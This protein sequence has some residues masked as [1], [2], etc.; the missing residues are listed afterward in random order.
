NEILVAL[1]VGIGGMAV[2]FVMSHIGLVV[3]WRRR[4]RVW[5]NSQLHRCR[6]QNCWPPQLTAPNR[7]QDVLTFSAI[8]AVLGTVVGVIFMLVGMI[9]GLARVGLAG[10]GLALV[11][12]AIMLHHVLLVK[13]VLAKTP[14]DCWYDPPVLELADDQPGG[15][16]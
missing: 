12:G 14:D 13:R 2:S 8:P 6:D 11:C 4:E 15:Y 5:L 7:V 1:G 3:A 16:V 10:S 9:G